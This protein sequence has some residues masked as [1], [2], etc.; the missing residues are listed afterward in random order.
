M[1]TYQ[2]KLVNGELVPLTP[3][4]IAALEEAE[5]NPPPLPQP[6]VDQGAVANQRLDDGIAAAQASM[7]A[8]AARQKPKTKEVPSWQEGD[9]I[10]QSQ[11]D[12]LQTAVKEMLEAQAGPQPRMN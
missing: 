4:E 5:K 2:Y 6:P 10:L 3:E 8:S 9:A 7:K 1:S 12:A 11:I